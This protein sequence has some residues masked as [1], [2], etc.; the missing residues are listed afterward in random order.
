MRQQHERSGPGPVAGPAAGPDTDP[1]LRMRP[2]VVVLFFAWGFATVLLDSLVPKLKGLFHLDYAQVLLTQFAFFL[3]YFIFSIPAGNWLARVGYVRSIITGLAAMAAGCLLFIPA[4]RIGAFGGFLVALFVMAAGITLLQVA[5]NPL[6]ARL[7]TPATSHSRL[8]LAQAFN[9][10]GTFVGPYIG[11]AFILANGTGDQDVSSMTAAARAA[12]R[13]AQAHDTQGPFIGIAAGLVVLALAFTVFLKVRSPL[14]SVGEPTRLSLGVLRD[15]RLALGALSI[16]TYV[17]AEVSIG[18]LMVNYLMQPTT[19][20]VT[21]VRAGQ[22]VSLYWGGAMVGRLIGSAVLRRVPAGTVLCVCALGAALL[23]SLSAL[24]TGAFAATTI[25]AVGLCNSIMFPT[26]FTLGI[27]KLGE[28]TPQGS[29]MLCLAIVGGAI[30]PRLTGL[31]AD[32]VGIA[33]AWFVP[34]SCYLWIACYGVLTRS[35]LLDRAPRAA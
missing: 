8:N 29:A 33:H 1:A 4:A 5:A 12:Y 31:T 22:L 9:S 20:G 25:I 15:A 21:A 11:A 16:F 14:L 23:A 27:E 19:L 28:R 35:R 17:G 26:I 32:R 10:L 34:V 7:G 13:A 18:S 6:I 2:L 30:I 3:A 24:N